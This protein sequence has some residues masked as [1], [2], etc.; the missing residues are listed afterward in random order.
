MSKSCKEINI[1]HAPDIH[2][3]HPKVEPFLI[4]EHME[5]YMFPELMSGKINILSIT[6]DFFH[7]LLNMNSDAGVYAAL[8]IDR[9][10]SLAQ[11]YKFYI[12]V[13]RG[14]FSHDRFQNRFFTISKGA[15]VKLNDKPLV[16]VIDNI[17]IETFPDLDLSVMYCPDDQPYEDLTETLIDIIKSY[18]MESVDVLLSHGYYDHM[19]PKNIPHIP[20]DTIF[21]DRINPYVK[22]FCLN[23]HVHS[24]SVY[25]NKCISGGSFERMV[26]G[27]EEDKGFFVVTIDKQNDKTRYKFVVNKEALPFISIAP[28]NFKNLEDCFKYIDDL[29]TKLRANDKDRKLFFRI[30]G[31]NDNIAAY[32]RESTHGVEVTTK[33]SIVQQVVEEDISDVSCDLPVITEE[34]L[35]AMV[36][37]GLKNTDILLTE[38]EVKEILDV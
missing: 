9:L 13:I 19:L 24:P 10:I 4:Y 33:S 6:G 23:G 3:G 25:Q 5:K 12:R 26:H 14:T 37:S 36:I 22:Y 34:N 15:E 38:Q 8:T 29:I 1:L 7:S 21:F 35:P 11:Y 27:E 16:R 32:L 31:D 2:F 20:T 17:E 30:I 28:S 18:H